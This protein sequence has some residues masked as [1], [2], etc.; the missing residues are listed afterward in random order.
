MKRTIITIILLAS[1]SLSIFAQQHDPE[2]DFTVELI[3]NGSAVR[4]TGY[5]GNR[6]AVNIPLRIRNL[7]V[8][9]IG[10][11]AFAEKG[12]TSVTI[13]NSVISIGE[14]AF[15]E[16]KLTSVT[17]PNSVISI[18]K[19]AFG[20]NSLV[21][22]TIPNSITSIGEWVFANNRLTSVTIG[23][24]V[25]TIGDSAFRNNQLTSVTIP[26]GVTSIANSA[27]CTNR[28]TSVVIPNSVTYL[29]GFCCGNQI[30]SI[31]IPN[32]VITI[33]NS[34]FAG[35]RL[36]N[37][38]I[39]NNVTTIEDFAFN[40]NQ[41]TSVTIG[42]RV[43]SIGQRAFY[44]NRLASVSIPSSV[45]NIGIAAFAEN[46][47]TSITIP[48]TVTAIRNYAFAEN[49]LTSV[50]IP[51][52]AAQ[53]AGDAFWGNNITSLTVGGSARTLNPWP[54][55]SR[56]ADIIF[57]EMQ[58]HGPQW[59]TRSIN[60]PESN[61]LGRQIAALDGNAAINTDLK[62]ALAGYYIG[63]QSN[64]ETEPI[65]PRNTPR[66]VDM[67][68]GFRVY[69]N[70]ITYRFLADTAAVSRYE[71][72]LKFITDRGNITRAEVETF[73]RNN[74]RGLINEIVDNEFNR[75]TSDS[76]FR[77]TFE[78]NTQRSDTMVAINLIVKNSIANFYL[79]PNQN[80]FNTFKT[81]SED[82][83]TLVRG[84]NAEA[85]AVAM[86]AAGYRDAA[87]NLREQARQYQETVS[88]L[89]NSL[90]I[91]VS[92]ISINNIDWRLIAYLIIGTFRELDRNLV[93]N[94][95]W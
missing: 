88:H 43:T 38:T 9:E 11:E 64:E 62:A 89:C 5:T 18:G 14:W 17:I 27:F 94:W 59:R 66:Q 55:L 26:N 35:N 84:G 12:I 2:S 90:S 67:Q 74:I 15:C 16:N 78:N 51:N 3:N 47:L 86:E 69:M 45:T 37:V 40:E 34:A 52:R 46:N 4:I 54:N 58:N 39:P 6:T 1:L 31:T 80:I 22:V 42:N 93:R 29:S 13:P 33:G 81:I 56:Y 24:S 32:G 53:I 95:R 85:S 30:A 77:F 79:S 63:W 19:G 20:D 75:I 60:Y 91:R 87:R 68:L 10:E 23:N 48:N 73:Y 82:Y 71:T 8:T 65:L 50:T 92:D 49:R 21:S 41:L 7:P 70:I 61:Q 76:S 72:M 28:L 36:T 25:R 44:K 83:N 57:G